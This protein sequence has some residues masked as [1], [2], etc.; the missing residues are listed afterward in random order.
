[1]ISPE[2]MMDAM[3]RELGDRVLPA[4]TDERARSSVIAVMGILGDLARQVAEDDG[5][6]RESIAE[7]EAGVA[8]WRAELGGLAAPLDVPEER[9]DSPA[10]RRIDL[11]G[12]IEELVGRL[13]QDGT[14]PDVLAD[15]RKVLRADLGGQLKRIR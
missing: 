6:A 5:W 11:L 12:A 10:A 1:M 4:V 2:H 14:R 3:R 13:W 9:S 15:V 7:L 8:R